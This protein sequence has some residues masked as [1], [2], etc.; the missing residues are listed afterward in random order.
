MNFRITEQ[1]KPQIVFKYIGGYLG[2]VS[3]SKVGSSAFGF[4]CY[5]AAF[6]FDLLDLRVSSH[7]PNNFYLS[8][9]GC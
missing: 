4:G 1:R 3:H 7:S 8:I 2:L 6:S 5:L 9:I